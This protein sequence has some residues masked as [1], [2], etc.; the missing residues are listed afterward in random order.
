MP[1]FRVRFSQSLDDPRIRFKLFGIGSAGCNIIQNSPFPTVAVSTSA[2][3]LER[4]GA[5][6]K[7]LVGRD[8]IIGTSDAGPDLLKSLPSIVGHELSDMFNN[9]DVAFMMCG[10]GGITGSYGTKLV[11]SIARSKGTTGIVLAA[12]PFSAESIRRRDLA[13]QALKGI[14]SVSSLCV[15]FGND[16]LS[17]LGSNIPLSR[18]FGILNGIMMRPVIDLSTT[19]SR[20]DI[21]ALRQTLGGVTYARFGLGLGRGDERSERAVREAITSPWFDFPLEETGAALAVYSASDAWEK[22]ALDVIGRLEAAV[23]SS[24]LIWGAYSDPS[25]GD[26]I[27]LSL[28]LCRSP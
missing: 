11:S 21:P 8:Q 14:A 17:S 2:S 16:K 5:G 13:S 18:A 6:R 4:S 10:L 27:R 9:T 7:I 15:E 20:N 3:D 28:L 22:E 12:T 23:P 19:V 25:L 26:R 24:K 1:N